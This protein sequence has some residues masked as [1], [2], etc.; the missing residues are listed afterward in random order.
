MT[1][2]SSTDTI[3]SRQLRLIEAMGITEVV[4]TTGYYDTV[5]M[6]YCDSLDLSLNIT[7]VN[8]P[9]YDKTNYIYSIYCAKDYLRDQDIVFMHGDLV[10]EQSVLEDLIAS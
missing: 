9:L 4:M 6:K 7:Y 3:L 2:V 5:L 1:E 8:N 10:F